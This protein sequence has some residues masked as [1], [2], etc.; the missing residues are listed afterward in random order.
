MPCLLDRVRRTIHQDD[1][2][3]PGSR[4]VVGLSGGADSVALTVLLAELSSR[5]AFAIARLA[6]LNHRLRGTAAD[7]DEAFCRGLAADLGLPFEVD[8]ADVGALARDNRQSIEEAGREARYRFF[9]RVA[10]LTGADRIAVGH[11]LEDQ[12]ETFL[13]NLIRGA[14]C[15]GLSGMPIRSGRII[16][17]LLD[18]AHA[19]LRRFLAE[20]GQRF[21]E[22]ET[23][24]DTRLLRNRVR[25]LIIPFLEQQF[26]PGIAAVLARNAAIARE[27]S[28]WLD[29]E[30]SRR[31]EHVARSSGNGI[32]LDCPLLC[33][34]APAVARRIA[35]RGLETASPGRFIGFGHV[36]ALLSMARGEAPHA[37]DFPGLRAERDGT[38]LTL[39]PRP[40]RGRGTGAKRPG[41]SCALSV[42]GVAVVDEI[43]MTIAAER[44][45]RPAGD[46]I[47]GLVAASSGRVAVVD[48]ATAAGPLRVRSRKAG[49]RFRPLGLAGTKKLQDFLVD[50]KVA[51][52]DRDRVPLVV[53]GL[54][55]IVW[56]GGHA[57]CEDFRVTSATAAV[58]IL[59]L[60]DRGDRA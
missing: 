9:D 19:D 25:H 40:G 43:G 16:R 26:S 23:N 31:W 53:D 21:R 15:R 17:P 3:P 36:E 18:T 44:G 49:D 60:E 38:R 6:H 28:A 39:H 1:L 47:E 7:E 55:R 13:L 11:T 24:R 20:R 51:A 33:R 37:A 56:V 57:I 41:F 58:V 59:R 46:S 22:D 14:G 8:R 42:P 5:D 30:A 48:L 54:D 32:V 45:P 29:A 50:R 52:R 35:L 34:E 4:V 12:A 2:I 27:D 10:D